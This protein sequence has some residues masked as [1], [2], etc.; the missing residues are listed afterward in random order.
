MI[1]LFP[2]LLLFCPFAKA[3]L[4]DRDTLFETARYLY[5]WHLDESHIEGMIANNEV[6]FL[7][8]AIPLDLDEGDRSEAVEVLI[9]GT[10]FGADLKKS[11]YSIPELGL[12]V[13]DDTF[14]IVSVFTTENIPIETASYQTFRYPYREVVD[15]LFRT[16][17][18]L[19]FPDQTMMTRLRSAV[20][21]KVRDLAERKG[22]Q[23]GS[24]PEIL[25]LSS[26]S[27]VSDEIWIFWERAKLLIRYA[28][29]FDLDTP[30]AW[31]HA[32]MATTFYD[33]DEQVVVSLEEV[34]GSNAYI[35]RDMAGRAIFNC[36]IL[37][38]R[39]EVVPESE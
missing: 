3:E 28:S 20:G 1:R 34:P 32:D 12:Q 8:K 11:D 37:G 25:H 19:A 10:G 2:L 36:V 24:E 35:T 16:R 17:N 30:D 22:I 18:D 38:K 4:P 29:E 7:A 26:L 27:P 5:R 23:L 31:E 33:L 13:K 39:I 14:K 6:V 21:E 9:Q 15:Y